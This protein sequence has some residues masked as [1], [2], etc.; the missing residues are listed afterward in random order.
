LHFFLTLWLFSGL[1]AEQERVD[2]LIKSLFPN[3][4]D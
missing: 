4:K 1:K 2:G 3:P